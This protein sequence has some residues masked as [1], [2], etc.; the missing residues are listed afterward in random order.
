MFFGVIIVFLVFLVFNFFWCHDS[1]FLMVFMSTVDTTASC[2]LAGW[3]NPGHLCFS[4][5][6]SAP[7]GSYLHVCTMCWRCFVETHV[8]F[9]HVPVVHVTGDLASPGYGV[10]ADCA[11]TAT[12]WWEPV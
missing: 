1:V 3:E 7:E 5:Y 4:N 8:A 2:E 11:Q 6:K 12:G 9:S 10:V